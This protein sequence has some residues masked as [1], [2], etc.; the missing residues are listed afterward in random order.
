MKYIIPLLLL[1]IAASAQGQVRVFE[2]GADWCGPCQQIKPTVAKLVREKLPIIAIDFDRD[3]A[4]ANQLGVT[5]I[6]AFVAVDASTKQVVGRMTG[7]R[8][9][10]TIRAFI[11]AYAGKA[12][13]QV[14]NSRYVT[15]SPPP[16][17][18]SPLPGRCRVYAGSAIGSGALIYVSNLNGVVITA[19]HVMESEGANIVF[20]DGKQYPGR[21]VARDEFY[22]L[23][24]IEIPQPSQAPLPID[25]SEPSGVLTAGGFGG[26]G[27][28]KLVR[29]PITGYVKYGKTPHP[30]ALPMPKIAGPVRSGD[31]GGAVVNESKAFVGVVWGAVD[32]ETYLTCGQPIRRLLD[33]VLP[34]RPGTIIPRATQ[35]SQPR[36]GG[37]NGGLQPPAQ[38]LQPSQEPPQNPPPLDVTP[39]PTPDHTA[40]LDKI[41]GDMHSVL[42]AVSNNKCECDNTQIIAVLKEQT[43]L[44]A[45]LVNRPDKPTA[46]AATQNPVYFDI[47]PR[48]KGAQ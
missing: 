34:N 3:R 26:D 33:R 19:N 7:A 45:V 38:P 18:T 44:L 42:V 17:Q 39:G 24:L 13:P 29:G 5:A 30:D 20:P 31:S 11:S 36:S 25:L 46:P 43:E 4:L 15:E 8:D 28:F 22:D 9:E 41:Q 23:A 16:A 35:I 32:G 40:V 1:L 6:P 14:A 37:S 47:K 12:T 21:V 10:Q 27:T 2:F 48:P